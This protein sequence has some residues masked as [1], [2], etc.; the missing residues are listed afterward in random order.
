[1][2]F[3]VDVAIEIICVPPYRVW[4]RAHK[5]SLR[6]RRPPVRTIDDA[7]AQLPSASCRSPKVWKRI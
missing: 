5:W 3:L 6:A 7:V 2:P 1:M 4:R